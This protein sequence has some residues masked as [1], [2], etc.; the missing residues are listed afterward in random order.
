MQLTLPMRFPMLHFQIPR[1]LQYM[2]TARRI[3]RFSHPMPGLST[4]GFAVRAVMRSFCS[5]QPAAVRRI[6]CRSLH[7]VYPGE[8][9][10]T[11]QLHEQSRSVYYR[12]RVKE[13]GLSGYVLLEHITSP[14]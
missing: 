14:L 8:T 13:R 3:P 9:L 1:L 10:V 12:T 2:K 6:S 5:M 11:E 7:Q 4:L